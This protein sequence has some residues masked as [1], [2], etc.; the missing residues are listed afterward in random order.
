MFGVLVDKNVS[1]KLTAQSGSPV[2]FCAA[3]RPAEAA[4]MKKVDFILT[5]AC[6]I[7]M[8]SR[9]KDKVL[10]ILRDEMMSEG[11]KNCRAE[12]YRTL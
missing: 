5:V 12:E 7:P 10:M 1:E 9:W 8:T 4:A 6:L 11:N 2:R 3:T